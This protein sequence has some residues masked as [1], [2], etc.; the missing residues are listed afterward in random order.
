MRI[1]CMCPNCAQQRLLSRQA[2]SKSKRGLDCVPGTASAPALQWPEHLLPCWDCCHPSFCG[3]GRCQCPGAHP[4]C[5]PHSPAPATHAWH[6]LHTNPIKVSL[7]A[8]GFPQ[9][10]SCQTRR[11]LHWIPTRLCAY[12]TYRELSWTCLRYYLALSSSHARY[13][14]KASAVCL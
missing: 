3:A 10:V 13:V 11:D 1:L 2:S 12:N 9:S 5:P 14:C 4:S 8:K 7:K 6:V